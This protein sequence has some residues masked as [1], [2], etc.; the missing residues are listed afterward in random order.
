MIENEGDLARSRRHEHACRAIEA[1]IEAATPGVVLDEQLTY[2][3]GV[4]TVG[5]TAYQLDEF[6]RVLAFGGGNGAGAVTKALEELLGDRI[7]GGVVVTDNP[8]ETAHVEM[9]EGTHPLPSAA[10]IEGTRKLLDKASETTEDDLVLTVITGGGSALLCAPAP[11]ISLDSYRSLTAQLLESGATIDE[12]NAVRKHLSEIKGGQLARE[13]TP[14]TVVGLVFSDVVGNRLD[15]IASGPIAP[16]ESTYGEAVDVLDRYG[17]EPSREIE[18]LLESGVKGE[19]PETPGP[20]AV[21]F[22]R[23]RTEILADNRTAIKAAARELEDSGYQTAIL[24]DRVE[25]EASDVGGVH[26]QIALACEEGGE[27]F[28]PPVALLS[29]GETTVTVTGDGSGG[30][31]QE[32][33]LRVAIDIA[34]TDVIAAAVDTD[35]IDGTTEVAG[36]LVDGKTVD[37]HSEAER[38]LDDND[39]FGYLDERNGLV[40]TGPTGT[41]VN[42]LRLLLVGEPATDS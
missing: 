29:G 27:P 4:L 12:I 41:N 15:V 13:L 36:A 2:Q 33:A 38:A 40:R 37:D 31:N 8:T 9:I 30:P 10:N 23:V 24:S 6:D 35:G 26:A 25:G 16:D 3:D 11:E 14:A 18:T 28:S 17:I 39:A 21:A 5:D 20:K 22:D 34:R 19:R 42:D 1:G 32:F 7:D